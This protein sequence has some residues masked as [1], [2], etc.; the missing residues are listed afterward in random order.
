M[1]AILSKANNL[2]QI[3]RAWA[4]RATLLGL[5]AAFVLLELSLLDRK[6]MMVD[7]VIHIPSGYSYL[8]TY[9]FRLNEEHPPLLKMLS[10]IGL[11]HVRPEL[12][13][14]SKGW[15]KAKQ[16]GDPKDGTDTFCR[17]FF[18]RNADKFEQIVYWG[19][20]PVIVVPVLLGLVVWAFARSLFDDFTA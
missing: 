13:L 5:M 19:R 16:P 10:G 1:R 17:D 15:S 11:E 4:F 2:S 9:D 12:P 18:Q 3:P 7:D 14:D 8:K 6:S 20:V